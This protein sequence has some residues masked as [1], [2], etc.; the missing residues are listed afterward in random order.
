MKKILGTLVILICSFT[1]SQAQAP[2]TP[3]AAPQ[4]IQASFNYDDAGLQKAIAENKIELHLGNLMNGP[5]LAHFDQTLSYYKTYYTMTVGTYGPTG[6]RTCVITFKDNKVQLSIVSRLFAM[7]GINELTFNGKKMPS[8]KF[9]S[10]FD[11]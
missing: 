7:N 4:A 5:Q 10:K 8:E 3:P 1:F 9:F 6:D 11:K 2:A